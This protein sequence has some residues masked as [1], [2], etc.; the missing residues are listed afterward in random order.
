[1]QQMLYNN[2]LCTTK[3]VKTVDHIGNDIL[4]I[5]HLHISL[6]AQRRNS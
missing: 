5:S 3:A 1:M 4:F 2:T 6:Q